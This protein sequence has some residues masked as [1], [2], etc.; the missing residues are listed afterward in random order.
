[1]LGV[2][3]I[4]ALRGLSDYSGMPTKTAKKKTKTPVKTRPPVVAILGHV[5]HG[6]TSILD[7]IRKARVA[8]GES[9]GITQHTGAYQVEHPSTGSGQGNGKTI[10]FLDTPGHEAFSAMRSRG[11]HVADIVVL[12]VAADDGVKPQTKEA[13]QHARHAGVPIIVAINKMDAQGA[14]SQRVKTQLMKEGLTLEGYG[15]DVPSVEVSAKTGAGIDDLLDMINLVGELAELPQNADENTELVVIESA[16]DPQRGASATLVVQKGTLKQGDII[17]GSSAWAKVKR[18]ED[19]SGHATTSA[20][21]ATPVIIIGFNAVPA[22]GERFVGVADAKAAE[23]RVATERERVESVSVVDADEGQKLVNVILKA[24]VQGTLEAVAE[25]VRTLES[26]AVKLRILQKKAGDISETDIRLAAQGNAVVVGF[27]V[28]MSPTVRMQAENNNVSIYTFSTIYDLAE[29]TRAA[30]MDALDP[31]SSEKTVGA[32]RVLKIF[33]TEPQR[34]IVG[35]EI[36]EG[37]LKAG[38]DIK[39]V[40]DSEEVGR[41]KLQELHIGQ[42]VAET[43]GEGS[44]VGILFSGGARIEEGDVLEGILKERKK[45][46]LSEQ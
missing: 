28:K 36:F 15:G 34:M 8:E 25:V 22:V 6:K 26:D 35:G 46:Q 29:G 32:L 42:Q 23:A 30:V 45:P 19:F 31:V 38:L 17:A 40:R 39:V 43:A 33:R 12:V 5:D 37:A 18:M 4:V 24:D 16:L 7:Y 10:T 20:T 11:A 14:D 3:R 1:V 27:R 2:L 41:G 44:E 13:L 9:G 21:P